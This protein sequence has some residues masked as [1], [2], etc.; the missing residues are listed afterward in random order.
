MTLFAA[1]A[2]LNDS[3]GDTCHDAPNVGDH[4]FPLPLDIGTGHSVLP[5]A[6]PDP[7]I[8]AALAVL[9]MPDLPVYLINGCPNPFNPGEPLE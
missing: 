8:A 3:D 2:N 7:N 5:G 6:E 4:S 1:W 9:S